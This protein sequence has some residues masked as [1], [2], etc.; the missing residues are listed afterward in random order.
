MNLKFYV[1]KL[2]NSDEL[3]KF[4]EE[5]PTA[6]VCSGFFVIDKEGNDSKVHFDYFIPSETDPKMFSFQMEDGIKLSPVELI[7]KRQLEKVSLDYDI[8][9]DAVEKLIIDRME[10]EKIK[11]KLQKIL[12]SFQHLE[13]KDYLVGT[14]FISGLGMLKINIELPQMEITLFEKKSIFEMVKRVK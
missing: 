1:E 4:L 6:Y 3:K 7:D 10:Q 8:D 13:G 11:N 12:I 14:V 5:N 2:E 9:F